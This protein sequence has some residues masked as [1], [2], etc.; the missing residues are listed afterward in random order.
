MNQRVLRFSRARRRTVCGFAERFCQT[1]VRHGREKTRQQTE[2][3]FRE[4]YDSD[5]S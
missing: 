4:L 5:G 2:S 1:A 3:K